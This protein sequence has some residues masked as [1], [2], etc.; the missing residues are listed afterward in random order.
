M[1]DPAGQAVHILA[2]RFGALRWLAVTVTVIA[3]DQWTKV[4]II[5]NFAQFESIVLLPVLEF[6]RPPEN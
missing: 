1:N 6:M 3:F 2:D 5:E 4:L